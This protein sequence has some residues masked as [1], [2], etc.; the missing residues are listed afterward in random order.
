MAVMEKQLVLFR[1]NWEN[2]RIKTNYDKKRK[3][4]TSI[5][6]YQQI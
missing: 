4:K 5:D 2:E 1:Q 6:N 3:I